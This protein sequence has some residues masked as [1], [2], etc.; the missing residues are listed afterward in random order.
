MVLSDG[1]MQE[2]TAHRCIFRHM[3][4]MHDLGYGGLDALAVYTDAVECEDGSI[5]KSVVTKILNN[6][7]KRGRLV[8]MGYKPAGSRGRP[9]AIY[10]VPEAVEGVK[11]FAGSG[12]TG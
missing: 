3:V 5:S 9:S 11:R 7:V 4:R 12:L 2:T 8:K 1:S 6:L 10:M